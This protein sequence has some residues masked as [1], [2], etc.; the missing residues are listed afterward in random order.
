MRLS[1]LLFFLFYFHQ[2][3][4]AQKVTIINDAFDDNHTGLIEFSNKMTTDSVAYGYEKGKFIHQNFRITK[5]VTRWVT[6][7]YGLNSQANTSYK[8]SLLQLAGL[9]TYGYGIVINAENGNNY[10]SFGIAASGHYLIN[11]AKDGISSKITNGWVKSSLVKAGQNVIN[12]LMVEKKENSYTFFINGVSINT[13]TIVLNKFTPN[14]G[15]FS[16][17]GMK[18]AIDHVEIQQWTDRSVLTGVIKQGYTPMSE[19]PVSS[20]PIPSLSKQP[21]V[22]GASVR[23][24]MLYR[25]GL[26]DKE[27]YR[28]I[29]PIF[30]SAYVTD[31]FLIAATDGASNFGVYDLKGNTIIP[32]I[33][34][35][36]FASRHNNITYFGC[37]S[38]SGLFGLVDQF[39]K[40]I[41]PFR[42]GYLDPISEGYMY[43]NLGGGWGLIDVNGIPQFKPGI[44]D[45]FYESTNSYRF[46]VK[47]KNGVFPAKAKSTDGGKVGLMNVSGKWVLMPIYLTIS[48]SDT[49]QYHIAT[50]VKSED[51][52]RFAYGVIDRSGK[53]IIPFKYSSISNA[54]KNYIVAEGN[55]PF[56]DDLVVKKKSNDDWL[57]FLDGMSI[58]ENRKWG[59]LS[60][61]GSVLIPLNLA[62]VIE[63]TDDK[64]ILLIKKR[65]EIAGRIVSTP[66]YLFDQNK[67]S[68]VSLSGYDAFKYDSS[69]LVGKP[70]TSTRLLFPSFN[71]G[72][73][74]VAKSNKWGFIDKTG[75]VVIPLIYDFA[76]AMGG[77]EGIAPS[78]LVKKDNEWFYINAAGK[79][80]PDTEAEIGSIVKELPPIRPG[81]L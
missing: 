75:K 43:A 21:E 72:L 29:D 50:Q 4:V 15:L 81:A 3:S 23:K 76:S 47:V 78:A 69:R 11:Y 24:G 54:G 65:E 60:S 55:S 42:Y 27:G 35:S 39:G 10:I 74:N 41:L 70:K 68:L 25:Y 8:V 56:E 30:R 38:A 19:L 49:N 45:D 73:M 28:I 62:N 33:M 63:T 80:I 37:E 51:A 79:R 22:Y 32:P 77:M 34:K 61:T 17:S 16:N 66:V 46:I 5:G 6:I 53:E 2:V 57:D 52:S 9:D 64:S 13:S 1:C 67:K 12:E 7:P 20:K 44:M 26:K 58:K 40:T 31:G 14:I 71:R 48:A 36:I 18:V 59:L